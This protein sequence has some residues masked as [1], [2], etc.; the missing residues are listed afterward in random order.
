MYECVFRVPFQCERCV[1]IL[2]SMSSSIEN[3][4]LICDVEKNEARASFENEEDEMKFFEICQ[5]F[6]DSVGGKAEKIEA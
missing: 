1:N 6:A 5:K 3:L 2:T 4:N